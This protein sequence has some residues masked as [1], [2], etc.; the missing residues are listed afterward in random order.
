MGTV[1]SFHSWLVPIDQ[2]F[3][4]EWCSPEQL[5]Q[6]I[7]LWT[8]GT[9]LLLVCA[10]NTNLLSCHARASVSDKLGCATRHSP[11]TTLAW[12]WNMLKLLT[13]NNWNFGMLNGLG[14][15]NPDNADF[16]WTVLPDPKRKWSVRAKLIYCKIS[17]LFLVLKCIVFV[18]C[19][20]KFEI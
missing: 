10:H 16:G 18:C 1:L 13:W 7:C 12:L 15:V 17:H 5:Q 11:G 8:L 9:Q 6:V 20:R 2:L 19:S 3:W 14:L 4:I